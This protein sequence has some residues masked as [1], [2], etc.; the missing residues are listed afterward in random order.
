MFLKW[1]YSFPWYSGIIN[2]LTCVVIELKISKIINTN[3]WKV[4]FYRLTA[5]IFVKINI[6]V[7]IQTGNL[8]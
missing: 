2:K 8:M 3:L 5:L 4:L 1:L 6:L 7:N